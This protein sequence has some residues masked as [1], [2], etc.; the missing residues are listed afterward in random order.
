MTPSAFVVLRGRGL[1]RARVSALLL[2]AVLGGAACSG[3]SSSTGPSE[4]PP[5]GEYRL[6]GIDRV[7]LPAQIFRGAG[8][9][10]LSGRYYNQLTVVVNDGIINFF[11]AERFVIQLNLTRTL[12]GV[13][14]VTPFYMAGAWEW[15]DGD[16]YF[17]ADNGVEGEFFGVLRNGVLS[18]L[19]DLAATGESNQ[20]D[21]RP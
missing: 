4:E 11:S 13:T 21:F 5:Q 2:G 1:A 6:Q 20:Y 18:V 8:V 12:D 7:A 9:D 19:I 10:P 15:D 3:D 17:E 14:R 16:I